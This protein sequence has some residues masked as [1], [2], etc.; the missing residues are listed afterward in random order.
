MNQ[1]TKQCQNCKKDFIIEPDDFVFYEKM[2][3]PPP[4]FC[5]EC[6][7]IRRLMIRNEHTLY[8]RKCDAPEHDEE[9]ISIYSSDKKCVVY[10]QKFWWSDKWDPLQFGAEYDFKAPFFLQFRKLWENVPLLTVSNSNAVNSEYCNVAD[11]SKDSYM[12]SGS[13]KIEKTLYSNRVYTIKDSMDLYACFRDELCYEDVYCYDSYRLFFSKLCRNCIDS[14]FLYDCR[15]CSHC[16]GCANLRNRQYCIWNEQYS[17]EEYF[18]KIKEF[19]IT[20]AKNISLFKEQFKKVYLRAIHKYAT[21][22][23]SVNVTGDAVENAK[24]CKVCFDVTEGAEDCKFIHWGGIQMNDVYDA[25]PGNGDTAELMYESVDSGLHGSN[26]AFTNVV[27]GSR[28]VRYALFC[29]DCVDIFG[30]ISLKNKRNCILNKQYS[31]EE[32]DA[33]VPKIKKHMEEMPYVDV[34]GRV[35]K[36]GEF[37]PFELA[38]FAYNESIARDYFPITKSEAAAKGYPWHDQDEK[39]YNIT[40]QSLQIPDTISAAGDDILSQIIGCEHAAKCDH[41]CT[42]AF[43]LVKEELDFY[44][45]MNLPI[46]KLCPNCRHYERLAQRNPMRLWHRQCM[47]DKNHPHHNGKCPNEFETSYAPDRPEIIYCEQCYNAEVA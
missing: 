21:I 2:K 34:K 14:W 20:N 3:V 11:Q 24:N 13:F 31:K 10:D 40:L 6:R 17:R 9:L 7:M 41:Q 4:T 38:P 36:Y 44:R 26:I 45:R 15:S 39:H 30:C 27:Y 1:E 12:A 29:H 8:R 43:K 28:N 23:K 37:F 22:F 35:Y 42:S 16:F 32:Y 33:L 25:G 47:C 5:P 19:D 18:S 46:P